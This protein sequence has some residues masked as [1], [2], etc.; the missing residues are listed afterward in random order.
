MPGESNATKLSLKWFYQLLLKLSRLEFQIIE[1]WIR[2]V[3]AYRHIF[4]IV[5]YVQHCVSWNAIQVVNFDR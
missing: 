1:T 3:M 5:I 4:E 2:T